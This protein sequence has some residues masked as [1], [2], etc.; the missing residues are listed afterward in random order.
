MLEH[1][2]TAGIC[3]LAGWHL[4]LACMYTFCCNRRDYYMSDEAAEDEMSLCKWIQWNS[5]AEHIRK[6]MLV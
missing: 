3:L 2:I 4:A 1:S 5:M 6:F